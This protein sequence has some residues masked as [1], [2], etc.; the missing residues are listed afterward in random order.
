M[1]AVAALEAEKAETE[2]RL[3]NLR[4]GRAKNITPMERAEAD[5]AWV[6]ARRVCARRERIASEMWCV[7][8]DAVPDGER[9]VE[10]REALG[11]DE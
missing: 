9:R 4:A 3:A 10:L 11:L 6:C 2:A 7:I 8:A 1:R 5:K